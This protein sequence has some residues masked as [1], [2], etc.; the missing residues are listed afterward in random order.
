MDRVRILSWWL[1][2]PLLAL[3]LAAVPWLLRRPGTPS[4]L[5]DIPPLRL[6]RCETPSGARVPPGLLRAS[7]PAK[8]LSP[9]NGAAGLV[10]ATEFTENTA[11]I[12][13]SGADKG[14]KLAELG[15]TAAQAPLAAAAESPEKPL[16]TNSAGD[17]QPATTAG[18]APPAFLGSASTPPAPAPLSEP[19]AAIAPQTPP[20]T[21]PAVEGSALLPPMALQRSEQ[22]ENI[23]RQ[24]DQQIRHGFDLAGRK[25][26]FA[27][28]N[29]FVTALRLLAQGLD[30]DQQTQRHSRALAAALT[31]LREADDF[32]P[33]GARLESDL[34]LP[35]LA[36]NHRTPVLKDTDLKKF[37]PLPALRCYLTFAQE[38]LAVAADNEVAG[39]MAL[40]AMG[41]LHAALVKAKT[42]NIRAGEAK[43]M[44]FFQAALLVFPQNHMAANDLGVL[45]AE[46]GNYAQ[47]R[48]MLEYGLA[49]SPQSTSWRNLAVIYRQLNLAEWSQRANAQADVAQRAELAQFG[50]RSAAGLAV[51][52]I[53]P[54]TFAQSYAQT[55]TAYEPPPARAP[56][57]EAAANSPTA[58]LLPTP[59]KRPTASPAPASDPPSTARAPWA[60]PETR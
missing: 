57:A 36:A 5:G 58:A 22:L 40:Y 33:S 29:E 21:V 46:C 28:Q 2:V 37:T 48:T 52:W 14:P 8:Y 32:V 47:A 39:S 23:A 1:I 53:D 30:A 31:A 45:L 10:I 34:D 11:G 44:A 7:Q 26:Y 56:A 27:A 38:Q 54:Q 13:P 35:T 17:P 41:K 20:Q 51:R 18:L 50:A 4:I 60:A 43:A 12:E 42:P 3:V 19:A 9:A 15:D 24:A 49:I 6:D 55:P 16:P 59:A 25:A